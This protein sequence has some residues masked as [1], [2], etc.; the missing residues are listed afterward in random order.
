MFLA[1]TIDF[2]F[3]FDLSETIRFSVNIEVEDSE[4]EFDKS[5]SEI[6]CFFSAIALTSILKILS[7]CF[8][9]AAFVQVGSTTGSLNFDTGERSLLSSKLLS[10]TRLKLGL[11]SFLIETI[12]RFS[13]IGDPIMSSRSFPAV[14]SFG[15]RFDYVSFNYSFSRYFLYSSSIL[16]C[17]FFNLG[18]FLNG[19]FLVVARF[20]LLADFFLNFLGPNFGERD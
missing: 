5:D 20:L 11:E 16:N 8:F 10:L 2:C 1:E 4:L 6:F 13:W 9:S 18:A 14:F 17:P 3:I 19:F 12:L 7:M 15:R